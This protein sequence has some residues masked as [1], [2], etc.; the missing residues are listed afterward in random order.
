[1]PTTNS[2]SQDTNTAGKNFWFAAAQQEFC[3]NPV[4]FEP[5]LVPH[6]AAERLGDRTLRQL[7]LPDR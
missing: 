6:A 1:M 4:T 2:N 7:Q 3:Y 5:V